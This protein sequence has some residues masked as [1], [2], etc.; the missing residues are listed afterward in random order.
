MLCFFRFHVSHTYADLSSIFRE[1]S[2]GRSALPSY[3]SLRTIVICPQLAR[4]FWGNHF[5]YAILRVFD[6]IFAF[7]W[8][9]YSSLRLKFI[10]LYSFSFM[11]QYLIFS[12]TLRAI[13]SLHI[14][15]FPFSAGYHQFTILRNFWTEEKLFDLI[16][17]LGFCPFFYQYLHTL[18]TSQYIFGRAS[19]T[20][21]VLL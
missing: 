21:F 19:I 11:R 3:S 7:P 1:G 6:P 20:C 10:I 18:T 12:V 5:F 14:K 16:N 17:A 2:L 9:I 15:P 13:L 4:T 8:Y